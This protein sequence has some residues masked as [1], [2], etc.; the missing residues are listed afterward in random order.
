MKVGHLK[1][2]SFTR[3]IQVAGGGLLIWQCFDAFS[4]SGYL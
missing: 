2:I 3:M 1:I 4:F